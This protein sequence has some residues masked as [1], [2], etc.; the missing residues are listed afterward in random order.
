MGGKKAKCG[1]CRNYF[2]FP[3]ADKLESSSVPLLTPEPINELGP[4]LDEVL[5]DPPPIPRRSRFP[6]LKLPRFGFPRFP[7]NRWRHKSTR[8][9]PL[10]QP[11]VLYENA[12][13]WSRYLGGYLPRFL[14]LIF[15]T[16][17]IF[18]LLSLPTDSRSPNF[19]TCGAILGSVIACFGFLDDY[20]GFTYILSVIATILVWAMAMAI[21]IIPCLMLF[22]M[23]IVSQNHGMRLAPYECGMSFIIVTTLFFLAIAFTGAFMQYGFFRPAA[24]FFVGFCLLAPQAQNF[25]HSPFEIYTSLYSKNPEEV[26]QETQKVYRKSESDLFGSHGKSDLDT[27]DRAV[28]QLNSESLGAQQQ[29]LIELSQI[30]PIDEKRELVCLAIISNLNYE[31]ESEFWEDKTIKVLN[32]WMSPTI[33]GELV[34]MVNESIEEEEYWRV[35]LLAKVPNAPL[36]A[37]IVNHWQNCSLPLTEAIYSLGPRAEEPLWQYLSSEDRNVLAKTCVVLVQVGTQKSVPKLLAL[38]NNPDQFVARIARSSINDIEK[39]R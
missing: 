6:Q 7:R 15:I 33:A 3:S 27:V 34:Q 31:P 32:D 22:L 28:E 19:F 1:A 8:S 36:A 26:C 37:I 35:K 24:V 12:V 21:A 13:E 39:K 29:A 14:L 2:M 17:G 4:F 5:L 25:Y 11:A 38:I 20:E 30:K 16:L 10:F 23:F 9:K 18:Y